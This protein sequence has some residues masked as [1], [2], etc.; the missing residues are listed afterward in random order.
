MKLSYCA[1]ASALTLALMTAAFASSA[2]AQTTAAPDTQKAVDAPE[3][4]VTG[5]LIRGTSP[6]GALPVS[7][8]T[9]IELTRQGSPSTVEM[10]KDLP[11]SGGVIGDANQFGAGRSEGVATINLR[12][13]GSARTLVLLNGRRLPPSGAATGGS[14][15]VDLNTIPPAAFGRMEVLKDGAAATYGSDAIGGVVNIIT[16]THFT[17]FEV[18]GD[19]TSIRGSDGDYTGRFQAGWAGDTSNLY[20]AAGFQHRSMLPATAR[21]FVTPKFDNTFASALA[22]YH[23]NPNG[24]WSSAANPGTYLKATTAGSVVDPGCPS[25]G[26]E[27]TANAAGTPYDPSGSGSPPAL[28]RCLWRYADFDHLVEN[29]DIGQ[30]YGEANFD[31]SPHTRLHI[32]ALYAHALS[33]G[34]TQSVTYG[35]NQYPG[36]NGASDPLSSLPA[37]A[38]ALPYFYIP[39]SNPGLAALELANPGFITGGKGLYMHPFFVRPMAVGGNPLFGGQGQAGSRTSDTFRAV[40]DLSGKFN[41]GRDVDWDV[42]VNYSQSTADQI[43]PDF[44]VGRLEL[45]LRGFGSLSTG[46]TCDASNLANAGVAAAGCFYFN[47][48]STGIAANALTGAANPGYVPSTAN[49]AALIDWIYGSKPQHTIATIRQL[50]TDAQISGQTS[51]RLPGGDVGY[52]LGMQYR[53]LTY[54]FKP[55]GFTDQSLYPC[56]DTILNGSTSCT[57]KNGPYTFYGNYGPVDLTTE[58]VAEFAEL[59]LPIFDNLDARVGLRHEFLGSAGATTNPQAR[60]KWQAMDWLGFRASAGTT[61]RAPPAA[62]LSPN[63]VTNLAFT[64]QTSSYKPYD[65]F[66]NPN[67]KPEKANTYS[68]GVIV[69]TSAFT[70]TVDYWKFDFAN[71][72]TTESG[73]NMIT[74]LFPAGAPNNCLT[75]G[76]AGLVSRVRF[77]GAGCGVGNIIRTSTFA[78]NGAPI[79][80][81]GLDFA[82][83]YRIHDAFLQTDV[84]LGADATYTINYLVANQAVEGV[85][86][87]PAYDAAG[88]L[89]YLLGPNSIPKWKGS[90]YAN[91]SHG[92]HNLRWTVRY[93]GSM[94]DQRSALFNTNYGPVT[95]SGGVAAT[96]ATAAS[97]FITKGEEIKASVTH[98]LTYTADLPHRSTVSLAVI[99]VFDT[100]PPFARLDYSYDP[101]TANPL[102]RTIKFGL[103]TKF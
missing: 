12:G 76:Y 92:P 35:P 57:V 67:L 55:G 31:L 51:V 29:T 16:P 73:L 15:F 101:F 58:A 5:T 80:T 71:P 50:T 72:L 18:G 33:N 17:G 84:V 44:L 65:T 52:A 43:T 21:S 27:L 20:F 28:T 85:V 36:V 4:V 1:G 42:A 2:N 87:T 34:D 14:P 49:S 96:C 32:E 11:S 100:N 69:K 79:K 30:L 74:A 61:F 45:A 86:V 26:G 53:R 10:I 3:V 94:L 97:C 83:T 59:A 46:V 78:I 60:L 40:A 56:V 102:G 88:K 22:A 13:L 77:T 9:A 25:L 47:P 70:A 90:A 41:L 68:A 54:D 93:I 38:L 89:N 7:V 98:D 75:P 82:G 62:S 19:Y 37:G 66:G 99:N 39:E 8:V 23:Y 6:T 103:K 63:G 81:S 48:F 95:Y 64:P 91:F 24:G